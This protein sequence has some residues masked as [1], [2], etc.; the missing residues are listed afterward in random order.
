MC[1][2]SSYHPSNIYA[3]LQPGYNAQS[4]QAVVVWFAKLAVMMSL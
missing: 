4:L 1:L 3:N 2:Y